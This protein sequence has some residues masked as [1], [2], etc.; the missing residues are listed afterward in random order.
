MLGSSLQV[1]AELA[2]LVKNI[3]AIRMQIEETFRD[4]KSTRYG[5]GYEVN[6]T[7]KTKRLQILLMIVMLALF[8]LR[9]LGYIVKMINQHCQYQANTVKDKNVLSVNFLGLRVARDERFTMDENDITQ[10]LKEMS[11]MVLNAAN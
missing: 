1:N 4:A 10:A 3:Y 11:F 7:Y 5:L 8:I 6:G 2:L 9:I